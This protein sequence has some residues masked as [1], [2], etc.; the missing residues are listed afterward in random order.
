VQW[1][2]DL[3]KAG[4]EEILAR[5]RK[6]EPERYAAAKRENEGNG[7]AY[8]D[9]FTVDVTADA[10]EG[11]PLTLPLRVEVTLTANPKGS[12]DFPPEATLNATME[13][14]VDADGKFN[15]LSFKGT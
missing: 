3:L 2:L 7:E 4:Q 1:Q 8:P 15:V 11:A 12:E 9:G 6:A 14:E 10:K 13:A 5:A